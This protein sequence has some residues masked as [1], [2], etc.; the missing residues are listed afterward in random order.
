M[1]I[2]DKYVANLEKQIEELQKRLAFREKDNNELTKAFLKIW[3]EVKG[4]ISKIQKDP[5]LVNDTKV[6]K[7]CNIT[8]TFCNNLEHLILHYGE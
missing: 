1:D 3:Q 2:N 7:L 5:F 8:D 6:K 4:D